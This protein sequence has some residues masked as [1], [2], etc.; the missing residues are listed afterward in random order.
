M[1]CARFFFRFFL[2]DLR[3]ESQSAGFVSSTWPPLA[4]PLPGIAGLAA[5]AALISVAISSV[6]GLV[7]AEA[8]AAGAACCASTTSAAAARPLIADVATTVGPAAAAAFTACG[9]V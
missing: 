8:W 1:C 6:L 4:A 2:D 3:I 5:A 9:P 7:A